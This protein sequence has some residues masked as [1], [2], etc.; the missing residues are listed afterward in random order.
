MKEWDEERL[1]AE[2]QAE[3]ER[4]EEYELSPAGIAGENRHLVERQ[5]SLREAADIAAAVLIQFPEVCAISL[6][7]SVARPL[8]K[9]VPRFRHYRRAG[10]LLWHE[11]KDVDIAVSLSGLGMLREMRR[12]INRALSTLQR[13]SS[14]IVPSHALDIFVF[15]PGTDRYLGRMCQFRNCPAH[16]AECMVPGCGATLFLQQHRDFMLD[17]DALAPDRSVRL[18]DRT[19]GLI[20]RAADLP[21]PTEES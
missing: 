18:Y 3:L 2:L 6:F 8:W 13:P 14:Y 15:E 20:R 5:R 7:G 10:I 16:K 21:G 11:C 9:E 19:E 4:E 1:S 12:R 17:S